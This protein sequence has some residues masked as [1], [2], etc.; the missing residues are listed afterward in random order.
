MF[1]PEFPDTLEH[2]RLSLQESLSSVIGE[3]V[4]VTLQI[5]N[6]DFQYTMEIG[7]FKRSSRAYEMFSFD[8]KEVSLVQSFLMT[9]GD[10]YL[11]YV[12]EKF[13]RDAE[14]AA[15]RKLLRQAEALIEVERT[16]QGAMRADP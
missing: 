8:G 10:F 6:L 15:L 13:G 5:D 11:G 4:L 1:S 3:P 12:M 2:F 9:A 7:G 14:I 16:R